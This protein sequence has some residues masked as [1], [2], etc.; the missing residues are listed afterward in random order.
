MK[1]FFKNSKHFKFKSKEKFIN[2]LFFYSDG[3]NYY[4]GIYNSN[5]KIYFRATEPIKNAPYK[6]CF[7]IKNNKFNYQSLFKINQN[8]DNESIEI[9]FDNI[10]DVLEIKTNIG[11]AIIPFENTDDMDFIKNTNNSELSQSIIVNKDKFI[12]N[13]KNSFNFLENNNIRQI[14]NYVILQKANNKHFLYSTTG[15]ILYRQ[16]YNADIIYNKEVYA[17]DAILLHNEFLKQLEFNLSKIKKGPDTLGI[18]QTK[19]KITTDFL[20]YETKDVLFIEYNDECS[21]KIPDLER[22]IPNE[23]L[24]IFKYSFS[25]NVIK[26][27]KEKLKPFKM[28]NSDNKAILFEFKDNKIIFSNLELDMELKTDAYNN[29]TKFKFEVEGVQKIKWSDTEDNRIALNYKAFLDALD[30]MLLSEE[31]DAYIDII[32]HDAPCI[33]SNSISTIL[34]MPQKFY[35]I[36]E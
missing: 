6:Y 29:N 4:Y 24:G 21:F 26:T 36:K 27:I 12:Q 15:R 7:L 18:L 8:C 10:N 1:N 28:L 9:N 33:I 13:F 32:K 5:F 30:I 14:L 2:D 25:K 11:K 16:E 31:E 34:I 17:Y 23:K 22:V 3:N 20:D 35:N 19:R